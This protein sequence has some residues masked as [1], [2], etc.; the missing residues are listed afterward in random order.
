MVIDIAFVLAFISDD[1]SC[2]SRLSDSRALL[3][4][5]PVS[6]MN[7]PVM[8][9]LVK[10]CQSLGSACEDHQ[11]RDRPIKP[12]DDTEENVSRLVVFRLEI[13]LHRL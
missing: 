1:P 7:L 12:V 5:G 3:D 4:D 13:G 10:A 6:L 11:S 9:H 2:Q 8:K